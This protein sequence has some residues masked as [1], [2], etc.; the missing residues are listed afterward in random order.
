[1]TGSVGLRSG[2]GADGIDHVRLLT[3]HRFNQALDAGRVIGVIAVDHHIDIG[4]DIGEHA[5]D[6]VAFALLRLRAANSS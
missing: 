5:P 6:D 3:K 2:G 4:L 1:V